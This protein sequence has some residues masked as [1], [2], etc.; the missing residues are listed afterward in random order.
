[1][2]MVLISQA[3]TRTFDPPAHQP[4]GLLAPFLVGVAAV[5]LIIAVTALLRARRD[6]A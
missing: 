3:A 4:T 6:R 2:R 1:M 5:A